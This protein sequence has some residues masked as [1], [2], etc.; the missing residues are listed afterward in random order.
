MHIKEKGISQ[1]QRRGTALDLW[2]RQGRLGLGLEL[3]EFLLAD[4]D[5]KDHARRAV[6]LGCAVTLATV[7]IALTVRINIEGDGRKTWRI[8][9]VDVHEVGVEGG[10][11]EL[12]AWLV[13]RGFGQRVVQLAE[14]EKDLVATLNVLEEWRIKIEALAAV[15][16]DFDLEWWGDHSSWGCDGASL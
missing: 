12:G 10:G 5:G 14:V 7:E 11:I 13:E 3:L 4:V 16:A 2:G 1:L 15:R 6:A 9:D 8:I